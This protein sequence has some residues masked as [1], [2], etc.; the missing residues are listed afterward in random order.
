[1]SFLFPFALVRSKAV[2][3]ANTFLQRAKWFKTPHLLFPYACPAQAPGLDGMETT[4]VAG[5]TLPPPPPCASALPCA[6]WNRFGHDFAFQDAE[7]MFENM[8][9]LMDYIN[10][11]MS[12]QLSVRY[13]TV[14]E[15]FEAVGVLPAPDPA[16]W[17]SFDVDYVP[18][19]DNPW[20][21]W[22]VR[23]GAHGPDRSERARAMRAWVARSR[24]LGRAD[25]PLRPQAQTGHFTSRPHLKRAIRT[26]DA[27]LHAADALYALA[28]P[29]MDVGM[30]AT[31][32]GQLDGARKVS[33]LLNHHDGITGTAA[34]APGSVPDT[35]SNSPL[36]ANECR[37]RRA[38]AGTS[39][40]LVVDDYIVRLQSATDNA[41]A[42]H[43]QAAAHLLVGA[44][45]A[46]TLRP[47]APEAPIANLAQATVQAPLPV[48]FTNP[49]GHA[50][51]AA[52]PMR[53]A[54]PVADA[55]RLRVEAADRT[56]V[57]AQV[58]PVGA[59]EVD[60][61]F[62]RTLPPLSLRYRGRT[63]PDAIVR[64]RPKSSKDSPA[65]SPPPPRA[66]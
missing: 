46:P 12:T 35:P 10:A 64:T 52:E 5:L 20:A 15:Y 61:V 11:N 2:E 60:V 43:A 44:A 63:P 31:A 30:R 48:L 55:A 56:P 45:D 59:D 18:F 1:M 4:A 9:L 66:L 7:I 32:E 19:E 25:G 27:R 41:E 65:P 22:W 29:S 38:G 28:A 37:R 26:L 14:S 57:Q 49:L 54:L 51:T 40:Q 8:D 47:V 62:V 34:A 21:G 39:R 17:P 3:L 6:P 23:R 13:G 53:L 42:V 58:T 50:I 24:D 16:A 36:A 33:A